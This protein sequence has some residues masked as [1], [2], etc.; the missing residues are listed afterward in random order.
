MLYTILIII[1]TLAIGYETYKGAHYQRSYAVMMMF[2]RQPDVES[3]RFYMAANPVL[4]VDLVA[5]FVGLIT[6][7]IALFTPAAI[8]ALIILALSISNV[9]RYHELIYLLDCFVCVVMYA[10]ILLLLLPLT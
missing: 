9:K 5:S 2:K 8:P 1:F 6:L 10:L 7:G 3:K 4:Y